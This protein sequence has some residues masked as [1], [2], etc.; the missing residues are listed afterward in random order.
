M[1]AGR[2]TD[3]YSN[4]AAVAVTQAAA[5]VQAYQE[6]LTGI[7]LGQG[8]GM[9][10]DQID[11]WPSSLFA[12]IVA[13]TDGASIAWTVTTAAAN[14]LSGSAKTDSRVIHQTD[15]SPAAAG[16]AVNSITHPIVSPLTYQFFPGLIVAAPRLYLSLQTTG[17]AA[18]ATAQSRI[19]FRYLE[20]SSQE[21][22]ELAEAFILVG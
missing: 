14:L 6:L 5:N 8:V 1:A 11:Y 13:S 16:V 15:L 17:F 7:S 20:L 2:P 12:E 18:V 9:V 3:K 4:V 22:L 19:Y 10:I 21:Y